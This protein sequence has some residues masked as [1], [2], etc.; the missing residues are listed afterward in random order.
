MQQ[1][2]G[3]R[4]SSRLNSAAGATLRAPHLRGGDGIAT[5]R[6]V[7]GEDNLIAREG[8]I[9]VLEASDGVEVAGACGDLPTL[10]EAVELLRPDVVLTDIR[11]P[12]TATDE[13]I[14][15]AHEL[16]STHPEIGVVVLSQYAEPDYA[17]ALFEHGAEGRAY[18]IKDRLRD[19]GELANAVREVAAGGSHVDQRVVAQLFA[20]W[21]E[22]TESPVARLTPRELETLALVAEGLSNSAIADALSISGRAVE[23]HIGAIFAKLDLAESEHVSRRVKAALLYLAMPQT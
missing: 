3:G 15:F 12:P 21:R 20:Q 11:M 19:R 7:L 4:L 18:L 8:I 10:R 1:A 14:R 17:N 6:V 23:R 5:I 16:R 9:R 22:R 2:E 13:G